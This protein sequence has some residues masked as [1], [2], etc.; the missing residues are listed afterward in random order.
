M[1]HRLLASLQLDDDS[2]LLLIE[3]LSDELGLSPQDASFA[4]SRENLGLLYQYA[5]LAEAM[6]ISIAELIAW[7]AVKRIVSFSENAIETIESLLA[8][9]DLI[10]KTALSVF[11]CQALC[12]F[13]IEEQA[14]KAWQSQFFHLIETNDFLL[15]KEED[16]L[17][18]VDLF[19][20]EVLGLPLEMI[21]VLLELL[22]IG[23]EP[24]IF[25]VVLQTKNENRL[26]YKT[27]RTASF[28]DLFCCKRI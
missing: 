19:L 11:D 4:L 13:A 21:K 17:A 25:L 7:K 12:S 23:V 2:L 5:R 15:E 6:K 14:V 16:A 24:P 8:T 1:V 18:A 28:N 10:G 3:H 9:Q 20:P 22:N 26:Q 27:V